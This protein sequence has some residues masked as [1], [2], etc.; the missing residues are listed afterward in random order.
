MVS[1]TKN[2]KQ[3]WIL[4]GKFTTSY[5]IS[6]CLEK[7]FNVVVFPNFYLV[8]KAIMEPLINFIVYSSMFFSKSKSLERATL[9]LS[10]VKYSNS[11]YLLN[12][13][14]YRMSYM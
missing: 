11:F 2:D 6:Y 9:G 12:Y 4:L 3:E 7:V 13:F 14:K 5:G 1:S 10:K 8:N